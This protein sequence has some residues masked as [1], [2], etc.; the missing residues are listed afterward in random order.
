MGG[1]LGN[2]E[3]DE[4]EAMVDRASVSAILE[5]LAQICRLKAVHLRD[6]WQDDKAA[7]IWL[8]GAVAIE[9]CYESKAI[10]DWL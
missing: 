4:L 2:S 1:R 3:T 5:A 10:A 6:N 9:K 8:R 7:R